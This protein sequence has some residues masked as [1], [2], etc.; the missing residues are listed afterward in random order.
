MVYLHLCL[1]L[2]HLFDEHLRYPKKKKKK[3]KKKSAEPDSNQRPKDISKPLQSSA[4]P[5][6]LSADTPN[7]TFRIAI[8]SHL[9]FFQIPS[10]LFWGH[11]LSFLKE[12]FQKAIPYF[13]KKC[14]E[15]HD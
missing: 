10:S 7:V 12:S 6:E 15:L 13:S 2:E 5:T 8:V 11:G 4:L 1:L 14:E 3:K 9:V